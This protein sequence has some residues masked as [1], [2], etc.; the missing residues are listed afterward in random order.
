MQ[1]ASGVLT[2]VAMALVLACKGQQQKAG[3][4]IT[5]N[6]DNEIVELKK[7]LE[8]S[9]NSADLH[10]QLALMLAAKGDW[11][12]SDKESSVAMQLDPHNPI[13]CIE[14]AAS[15]RTR[16]LTSKEAEMLNRAVAIDPRNPL[17]HFFLGVMYERQSDSEKAMVEFRET[18]RLIDSLSEA[19][20]TLELR[21]RI[22]RREGGEAIY[23]DQFGKE[24]FLH[25]I[26]EP[27]KKK[28]SVN[29][30]TP[31]GAFPNTRN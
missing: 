14:A 12:G 30:R 15:Y 13:L 6:A 19:P 21:N 11:E 9:P 1:F 7:Q 16:G 26:L 18:K 22:V 2:V 5:V 20:P 31:A 25:S 8:K 29:G 28:L 10:R 23:T 17:S 27:L 3:K 4:T 24:Y